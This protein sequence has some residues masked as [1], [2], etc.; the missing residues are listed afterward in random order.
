MP[1]KY[2]TP[3]FDIIHELQTQIKELRKRVQQ[4]E[5]QKTTTGPVYQKTDLGSRDLVLGQVFVGTDNTIN[6][7]AG[8]VNNPVV[9]DI[10][11][12]VYTF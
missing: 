11:G 7:V 12:T 6:Y 2:R 5:N 9:Y 10:H 8:T 4:L 3:S 1:E